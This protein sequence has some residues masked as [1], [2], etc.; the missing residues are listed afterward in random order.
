LTR[1]DSRRAARLKDLLL[2]LPEAE[3]PVVPDLEVTGIEY[4]SRKVEPGDLFVAIKGEKTDG[5]L[6]IPEAL[7]RGSSA[8]VCQFRKALTA[9]GGPEISNLKTAPQ[10]VVP[11]SR[12]TLALLSAAFYGYPARELDVFGITGT[13]GKTTTAFLLKKVL[14]T[15]GESV[16]LLTTVGYFW[17]KEGLVATHTTPESR[18]LQEILRKMREAGVTKVV[19]EVSSHSQEMKRTYGI[20][21]RGAVFTNLTQDHL[22]FHRDMESYFRAKLGLFEGLE[23]DSFGVLNSDDPRSAEIMKVLAVPHL[24][25]GVKES[26]D[27]CA[28]E[29]RLSDKGTDFALRTP[30]WRREVHLELLGEFNVYNALAAAGV[31]YNLSCPPDRIVSGLASLKNVPGRAERV[32]RGQPF[33]VLVDYAHTP[34]AL[35]GV[36]N[37]ARSVCNRRIVTIFG[38][39]GDRDRAKRPMMGQ[40]AS[41]LSDLTIVTSDNPRS[42][43]P[44]KIIAEILRGVTPGG[45]VVTI[46][47]RKE[48]IGEGLKRAERG[49]CV[50]IAGKGHEEYQLIGGEVHR[51]SDRDVAESFLK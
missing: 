30:E 39:G 40:I 38:C 13:N 9:A 7:A 50:V 44:E 32:D 28:S 49:D 26:S 2:T 6:Y 47:D 42:E 11:D 41:E 43:E 14:E 5:H 20:R 27:I 35:R 16:G 21:F 10:V 51:F 37:L 34:E 48:A 3:L 18:D 15:S 31:A 36:L 29:I 45:D 8:V 4:D 25:Y 19:M 46:A 17:G 22:D 24:T 23:K 33:T 12:K 1:P